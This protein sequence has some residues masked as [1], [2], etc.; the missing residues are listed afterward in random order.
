MGRQGAVERVGSSVSDTGISS[1]PCEG[2]YYYQ[3]HSQL[4]NC[5]AKELVQWEAR[6]LSQVNWHQSPC[7][8]HCA[9]AF[10]SRTGRKQ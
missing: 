10:V 9:D 5:K 1:L 8:N 2:P 6:V 7:T 3:S 4:R